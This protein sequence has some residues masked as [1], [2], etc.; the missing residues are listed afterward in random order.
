M[1]GNTQNGCWTRVL[2]SLMALIF[3][4]DFFAVQ[5]DFLSPAK[6]KVVVPQEKDRYAKTVPLYGQGWNREGNRRF[7]LEI[8][9]LQ[10]GNGALW[11]RIPLIPERTKK[12]DG[13]ILE[14]STFRDSVE[15]PH[16]EAYRFSFI[17]EDERARL[18]DRTD[19]F[20]YVADS[21]RLMPFVLFGSTH[22]VTLFIV[23]ICAGGIPWLVY[24]IS[25]LRPYQKPIA[26]ALVFLMLINEVIYHIYWQQLGAWSVSTA[27]MFHMCGISILLLPWLFELSQGRLQQWL[28]E[29]LYF[30]G[31]G[32]ALQALLTPDIGYLGFPSYKF[33]SFFISHGLI[34][35]LSLYAAVFL[36]YRIRL[37]SVGRVFFIS[38]SIVLGIYG[39][40]YF[41]KWLPPYEVGNYFVLSYPPPTGSVIDLFEQWFGPSPRYILGLELMG[42][43][44]FLLMVIPWRWVKKSPLYTYT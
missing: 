3:G 24:T 8:Y 6:L 33:F 21:S 25:W 9:S 35:T 10:Q 26:R 13:S 16:E 40:N 42:L 43:I 7:F 2:V 36:P 38:N 37:S 19:R 27:L 32:G 18:L 28:F 31:I 39:L 20:I 34:I 22:L 41:L 30:W 1:Q 12:P 17:L 14:L 44:V 15:V 23:L 4:L 11:K 29:L 5:K